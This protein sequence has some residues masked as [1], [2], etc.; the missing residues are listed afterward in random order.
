MAG[1][2]GVPYFANFVNSDMDISDV[3][4]M[5]LL[6]NQKLV[7]KCNN[8]IT[9]STIEYL[10]N[11]WNNDYHYDIN[12]N[13]KLVPIKEVFKVNYSD[14]KNIVEIITANGIIQ[15][16]SEDHKC[17]IIR[18]NKEI[19][20]YSQN[21][22]PGDKCILSKHDYDSDFIYEDKDTLEEYGDFYTVEI[23]DVIITSKGDLPYVYN[24]EVDSPDHLYTLPN[25][26]I[27]HQCC[28]LRLDLRELRRRNGGLFGSGDSTGSIGVV[29]INLPRLAYEAK[30]NKDTFFESL[31]KYL[32]LAKVSLQIK[33]DWLQKNVLEAGLTPA[34][35][36]YVGTYDNHFNT[37]GIIGMNEMCENLFHK[38]IL[39][40]ES[41]QFCLD[42]SNHIRSKLQDF[43]EETGVL[44]NYEA[45]PAE[46]TSYRLA[47]M[48]KELYP[49][50]ITQGEGDQVY[51]T[52]SS[53]IPVKLI[54]DIDSTFKH[55]DD[56]QVLY[57]G[58][59]VVH[60]Y[61]DGAITG[62]QAKNIVK[63]ILT[64]YKLPYISLSPIS[65]YCPEHGYVEEMVDECPICGSKLD[66]LQRVVGYLRLTK[67]FNPGK[68]KEFEER[69][70]LMP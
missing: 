32:E 60:L 62:E 57:S 23:T 20:E 26:I 34:F 8:T 14:Y 4:S 2:Y 3:R 66:S 16:F 18:G 53:H 37:I 58:G 25:G 36:E 51:Y 47:K 70:Q 46:G 50:I 11:N 9:T 24:F 54:E 6:P 13:G 27:T 1:K 61:L 42:V 35:M 52:N 41:R 49:D 21:I 5:A 30:G 17:K 40:E 55:Q 38:N 67:N 33:R 10:Y 63:T 65:R 15:T 31:D 22:I 64:K 69:V 56:L 19:I 39:D 7:Y 59:T 44:F 45:T 43:Q 68:A 29:T 48:D 12:I 28:R